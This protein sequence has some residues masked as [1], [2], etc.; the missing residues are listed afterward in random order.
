MATDIIER[1]QE[2][3]EGEYE[4]ASAPDREDRT[5]RKRLLSNVIWSWGT[6]LVFVVAGFIMPRLI[7]AHIGQTALGVW[8]FGWSLVN[9][10]RLAQIG[11]GAS[12][13]RYV[14]KHRAAGDVGAMRCAVA[15]VQCLQMAAALVV[16]LLTATV[17][18]A[19]P[20][21]YGKRLGPYLHDSQWVIAL[22]GMSL[23]VQVALDTFD[24]VITGCH[25][26]DLHYGIDAGFYGL[27]VSAMI[28]S[29]SAGGGLRSLAVANVVGVLAT[30]V[31]RTIVA[32]R[33]C[34]ELS[35]HP[36]Y[37]RWAQARRMLMYGGKLSIIG[38]SR[39]ILIQGNSLMVAT[40]L[41][42]AA[43]ALYSRPGALVRHVET[44]ANKF[45]NV[46]TPTAS[47]LQGKGNQEEVRE[48]FIDSSRMGAFLTLPMILFLVT[49][50][51]PIL[52]L[53]MGPRYEQG[54]VLGILAAG[55]LL[56]LAQ[57]SVTKVLAGLNLHGRVG[58]WSLASA[59]FG[60][61][62]GVFTIG[63]LKWNLVGGAVA[64]ATAH[65]TCNGLLIPLYACRR[66][67]IPFGRY[68]RRA[69]LEPIVSVIPF[70]LGLLASRLLFAE[71]PVV[72]LVAGSVSGAVALAPVYWRLV[73]PRRV[74]EKATDLASRAFA[75][76]SVRT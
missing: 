12:V 67:E 63:G 62:L 52:R 58:L 13:N 34:P 69:L 54:L 16:L 31:A 51:D 42:P 11:I 71:R 29:L 55:Y 43:L 41:G 2:E 14:A 20:F 15:S 59:V 45:A 70:A 64:V 47:S 30:E 61:G 37:A 32:Y 33:I 40:Y 24:G 8:D 4:R 6:H 66:L 28:A 48:F 74:R 26:W 72:A 22:L 56:P 53:W 39:L 9:Y 23:A 1:P 21:L 44:F 17:T 25:R 35:A 27:T 50:G 7:D 46:L 36:R 49:L 10:F 65:G 75:R 18:W 68:A 3:D 19:L 38:L 76:L 73:T 5:G 57:Q 60:L